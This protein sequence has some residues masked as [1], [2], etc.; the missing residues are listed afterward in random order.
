MKII[1]FHTHV[2]TP[3]TIAARERLAQNDPWFAALYGNPKARMA[4][5]DDLLKSARAAGISRSVVFTFPWIDP[6]L[7]RDANDYVFKSAACHP[8][9]LVPFITLSPGDA[10][11]AERELARARPTAPRG[12][13]EL[14]PDGN[15][16]RLSDL[17][18]L[19]PAA[20]FAIDRNIPLLTHASE[21][22]GHVYPGKG[23]THA[24][25]ILDLAQAF[26]DLS[27]VCG[28]W[29]GGLIFYEL[30]PEI[31]DALKNVYYDTSASCYVYRND[32]YRVASTICPRKVLFGTDYP[33]CP[34][35][36]QLRGIME[37][38]IGNDVRELFLSGN[39]EH[40]LKAGD[41]ATK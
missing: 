11:G 22:F 29:G 14:M 39:A 30:Q 15:G 27:I 24:Q 34:V 4:T 7:L 41:P 25:E 16:Y 28:H 13:G 35:K 3:E 6:G 19:T 38:P 36:R 26:P 32:I 40:L 21:P 5:A 23:R 1:D 8:E 12:I 31:A 18:V 33:T 2:F 37:S 17:A 10:D 20:R 9:E